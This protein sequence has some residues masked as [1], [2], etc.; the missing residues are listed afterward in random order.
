[1]ERRL[2]PGKFLSNDGPLV[3]YFFVQFVEGLL[4]LASPL[5]V[6]DGRVEVVVVP[7]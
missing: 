7:L 4:L 1:M 3:S 6:D 2:P 5:G